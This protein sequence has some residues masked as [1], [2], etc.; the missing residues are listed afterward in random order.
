MESV[1]IE[2]F[3]GGSTEVSTSIYYDGVV[4][5]AETDNAGDSFTMSHYTPEQARK[6]AAALIMAAEEAERQ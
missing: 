5:L 1:I 6:L 4:S 2:D 3:A